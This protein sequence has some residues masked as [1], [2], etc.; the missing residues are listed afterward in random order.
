MRA[1]TRLLVHTG[2]SPQHNKSKIE[3]SGHAGSFW[4]ARARAR[5]HVLA[6]DRA[7]SRAR[8][9]PEREQTDKFRVLGPLARGPLSLFK[10]INNGCPDLARVFILCSLNSSPGLFSG[11]TA[12]RSRAFGYLSSLSSGRY[13]VPHP[14]MSEGESPS[15]SSVKFLKA[16][17]STSFSIRTWEASSMDRSLPR[18]RP[19]GAGTRR[20]CRSGSPWAA[21]RAGPARPRRRLWRRP[22]Q[23]KTG[24]L[25]YDESALDGAAR[26]RLAWWPR[27]PE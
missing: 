2:R 21:S 14:G 19:C 11:T 8:Q 17:V 16:P 18:N 1:S 26:P 6:R 27:Y 12:A 3:G 9:E 10:G 15:S 5:S 4:G 25:A 23:Q 24:G 20:R 13:S 22:S 7:P